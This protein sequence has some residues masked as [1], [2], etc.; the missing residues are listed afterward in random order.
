MPDFFIVHASP[1]GQFGVVWS[2]LRGR[3]VIRRVLLSKPGLPAAQAL[4]R[5]VP[6]AEPA[7]SRE[8]STVA[9]QIAAFLEGEDVRFSIK[10]VRMDLC[11]DFQGRVLRAEH[12]I[13]RGRVSTYQRLAMHVGRPRG[14]RAAGM[15]LAR[16]P[17]PIIVPCHRAIRS[18][19]ELGGYQG[20]LAMKRKLL[21]LEGIGFD[22]RGRVT[23]TRYFY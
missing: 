10:D 5:I 11:S 22:D 21:E 19:G 3:P 6:D 16:N 23:A 18:G 4:R 13:P 15:A 9:R 2:V 7:T 17:F 12:G 1:F 20:G 8:I 14:A